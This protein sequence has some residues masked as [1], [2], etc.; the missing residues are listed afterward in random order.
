MAKYLYIYISRL[1]L[2]YA[3]PAGLCKVAALDKF[4]L[5]IKFDEHLKTKSFVL[6]LI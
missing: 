4:A 3:M 5:S 6:F 2:Q 1:T